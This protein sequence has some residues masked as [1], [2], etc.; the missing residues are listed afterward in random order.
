MS[1]LLLKKICAIC[2][3][4]HV[5]ICSHMTEKIVATSF[6][7]ISAESK[8]NISG[9]TKSMTSS[10]FLPPI[11]STGYCVF[12][13][14]AGICDTL[15]KSLSLLAYPPCLRPG[16]H[17]NFHCFFQAPVSKILVGICKY[18]INQN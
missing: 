11:R 12:G 14:K 2:M 18:P 17:I 9:I 5:F 15:K 4:N 1:V 6:C 16:L 8:S 10:I 7:Y 3:L 13:R